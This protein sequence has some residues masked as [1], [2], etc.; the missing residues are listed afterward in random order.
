MPAEIILQQSPDEAA[1]LDKR[2][3]LTA[4]RSRLAEHEAELAQLR[5]HDEAVIPTS[6]GEITLNLSDLH[7]AIA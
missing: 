5:A 1:L 6:F 2:E 4:V 7:D 3:Q